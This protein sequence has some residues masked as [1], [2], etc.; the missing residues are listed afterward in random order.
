[1]QENFDVRVQKTP[2]R[3]SSLVLTRTV[4]HFLIITASLTFTQALTVHPDTKE[5]DL[6]KKIC[7]AASMIY[8]CATGGAGTGTG[9]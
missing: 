9:P 3:T 5:L 7:I 8:R 4:I 2:M 1:M 6:Q